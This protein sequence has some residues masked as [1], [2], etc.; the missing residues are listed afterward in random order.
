M[1]HPGKQVKVLE[2]NE[3]LRKRLET[4]A[5]SDKTFFQ[6]K[7]EDDI[8]LNAFII[9]P[10]DFDSGK[11]YPVLMYVYGRP[12]FSGSNE[13]LGRLPENY[14]FSTSLKTGIL[15]YVWI[16]EETGGRGR[17]FKTRDIQRSSANWKPKIKL[18]ARNIWPR[19]LTLIRIELEFG[20][21]AM[22][23]T[24]LRW[25]LFLGNDIFKAAIAVAPV[26]NWR[27]YDSI[28]T[29]R[30]LKTPQLNPEGYDEYSPLRPCRQIK[31]KVP[32]GAWHRGTIMCIIKIP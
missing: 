12:W 27:F 21:G 24:C 11:K 8:A 26:T 30:Y 5:W 23:V 25:P 15:W 14:G 17:V 19:F 28:Y 22:G 32:F 9:K 16:T 3:P 29:E 18:P 4:Y 7:T 6:F 20:A 1:L 2:G 10:P 31:R 13:R